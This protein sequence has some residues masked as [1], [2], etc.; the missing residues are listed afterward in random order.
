MDKEY[1]EEKLK[2]LNG[3]VQYYID[4]PRSKWSEISDDKAM[5]YIAAKIDL[6]LEIANDF[7]LDLKQEN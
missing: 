5:L 6:I 4:K 1:L 2:V 7:G 3:E